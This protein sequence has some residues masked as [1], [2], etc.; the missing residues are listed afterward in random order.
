MIGQKKHTLHQ[1]HGEGGVPFPCRHLSHPQL[2]RP[3][4]PASR[5]ENG[6][7]RTPRSVRRE[8]RPPGPTTGHHHSVGGGASSTVASARE[9]T[10]SSPLLAT[11]PSPDFIVLSL[12]S[13]GDRS[14]PGAVATPR[15]GA[16]RI[17]RGR[18]S[19]SHACT[20]GQKASVAGPLPS[21]WV[22]VDPLGLL[23]D[24][25]ARFRKTRTPHNGQRDWRGRGAC[26]AWG[27]VSGRGGQ[28]ASAHCLSPKK[29]NPVVLHACAHCVFSVRVE[30][31]PW[32]IASSSLRLKPRL[33]GLDSYATIPGFEKGHEVPRTRLEAL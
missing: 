26:R 15:A 32:S 22:L 14:V 2:Q 11:S 31:C 27:L 20:Q 17:L 8:G 1:A 13:C 28:P 24:P 21:F 33:R 12:D 9:R 5:P 30:P 10:T 19:G 7:A 29:R 23:S 4:A 18:A 6:V 16:V 3:S 25:V